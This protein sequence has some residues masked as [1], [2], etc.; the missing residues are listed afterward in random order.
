MKHI[1]EK[2]IEDATN[3]ELLLALM[4]TNG[5]AEG[6]TKI[7]FAEQVLETLIEIDPDRTAKIYV[8]CDDLEVLKQVCDHE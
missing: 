3:Q 6:P 4:H 7:V 8:F 2:K 5:I 1:L